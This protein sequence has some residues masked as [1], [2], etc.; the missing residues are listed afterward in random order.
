[1]LFRSVDVPGSGG[2]IVLTGG[3]IASQTISSWNYVLNVVGGDYYQLMWSTPDTH[4]RL[5]YE[6]A[7]TSP[8]AHPIIPSV[9]LTVTQQSGIMAGT[10]LTAI[11][12]LTG[13][14][15]TLTTG[16]TGIDFAIVDSGTDHKFN[17][18]TASASARGALSSANWTTFNAKPNLGLVQAMTV[19][20]QNIF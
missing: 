1:M 8:F 20:L 15:Q 4:V 6:A 12:S 10:G 7:Q 9:I 14:V 13:A 5:L 16:T 2:K 17:L 3:A 11:N 19:G 18:P